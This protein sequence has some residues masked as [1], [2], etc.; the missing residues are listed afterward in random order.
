MTEQTDVFSALA[1]DCTEFEKLLSGLHPD[2]WS[3]PTPAPRWSIR[4]QVAHLTAVFRMAATAA[5]DPAAFQA[6][7]ASLGPDFD[8]NV[9]AA[10][11]RFLADAGVMTAR[12]RTEWTGAVSALSA[13]PAGTLVP[14]LVRPIPA[15]VLAAAGMTELFGH[16]HDVADT[17]GVTPQYTDRI[18][19]IVEFGHRTWDF[20]YLARDLT[21]PA[22]AP[23]FDLRAPSGAR[24]VLGADDA[25]TVSG[26]AVDLC[27]LITRRRHRADLGLT[28]SG[29]EADRWLDIAQAYRGPAGEG[30]RP[31]QF[32]QVGP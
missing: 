23:R 14:W 12:W 31:G 10:L 26:D 17:L 28:A 13:V 19:H 3:E 27:L 32:A 8:A 20:G 24:W 7:A 30:R 2:L 22:A 25:E 11:H 4:H 15:P 21:P 18:G 9:T 29:P 6:M 1:A 16:G 5:S